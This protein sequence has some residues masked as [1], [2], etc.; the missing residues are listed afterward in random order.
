[1]TYD[2]I[3]KETESMGI[4][5]GG[6]VFYLVFIF[7]N[8][9]VFLPSIRPLRPALAIA[10]VTLAFSILNKKT[11]VLQSLQAKLLLF[12]L[13]IV[14]ASTCN[15][16]FPEE[17]V[18]FLEMYL[19]TIFLFFLFV[20]VVY[21]ALHLRNIVWIII[22]F[23]FINTAVTLIAQKLGMM[24]YRIVS[25]FHIGDPNDFALMLLAVLPFPISLMEKE[26]SFIRKGFL[27]TATLSFLLCL[28]RTRSR[29]GFY[30]LILLLAQFAWIKRKKPALLLLIGALV[31]FTFLNTHNRYFAR[32]Q[33]VSHEDAEQSRVGRWR[34]GIELIKL[35]PLL[36]V[37]PGNFVRS[38]IDYNLLGGYKPGVAHNSFIEVGAE[39]GILAL[40]IYLMLILV[41]IRDILFAENHF[42]KQQHNLFE[43]AQAVRMAIIT[44][45]FTMVFLSQQYNHFYYIFIAM[46]VILKNL[47]LEHKIEK[48]T[49]GRN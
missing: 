5:F 39:N 8:P 27:I 45:T 34:Q 36:G 47:A 1:M 22:I 48:R 28:T 25:Y 7:F 6:L 29:M 4:Q 18:D 20:L 24:P 19:K 16:L 9:Q 33:S 2:K 37:G 13:L 42:K 38:T 21:T 23:L 11:A 10:L 44:L 43:I 30:G 49:G 17:S 31:T 41:S 32:I 35:K 15:S 14:I 26:K 46:S 40:I 12:F 3:S